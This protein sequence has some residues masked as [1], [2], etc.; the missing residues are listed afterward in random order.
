MPRKIAA[1]NTPSPAHTGTGTLHAAMTREIN[2][3]GEGS[4]FVKSERGKFTRKQPK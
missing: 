2:V 4:R 1:T 3:K